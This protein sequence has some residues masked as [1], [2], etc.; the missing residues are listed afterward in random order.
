METEVIEKQEQ[1]VVLDHAHPWP[2]LVSFTEANHSF[3]F[4]R[5]RE[6]S[7]LSRLVRQETLTVFFGK[8]GLGKSSILRAGLSPLLRESDFIPIYIRLNHLEAAP[9]LEDQVEVSIEEVLEREQIDA[10]KPVRSETLWEYFHKKNKDWW[11]KD[12]RLLKPIL[13]FDQFEELMTLGQENPV[14]AA[15]SA[16]FLTELEDLVENRPPASLIARFKEDRDLADQFDHRRADYRVI[17]TLRED[18]LA[19]LEGLRER[20]SAVMLNRLR[21][22]PMNGEQALA[23]VLKPGRDLVAEDVAIRIVDFVSSSERSRLQTEV[24]R[25]QLA[26]R[27]IEPALLSVVLQELN[28]RRI[29]AGQEKITAELVGKTNPTEIF[30]DFYVRGLQ[31]MDG[32][33]REFIEDSLLTSSGARNRIAEEDALTRRGISADVVSKLIDRRIIQRETT[34][35]TKWLELTHDTLADVVRADRAEHQQQRQLELVKAQE[36]E[37]RTKLRRVQKLAAAFAGL[38][39]VALLIL[40][41]AIFEQQKARQ[42]QNSAQQA[43]GLATQTL[44]TLAI[45]TLR[46]IEQNPHIRVED[47]V[48]LTQRFTESIQA[49]R[50]APGASSDLSIRLADLLGTASFMLCDAGLI[51]EGSDY[52]QQAHKLIMASFQP[53]SSPLVFARTEL[54]FLLSQ[55]FHWQ[56]DEQN[57]LSTLDRIGD[58]LRGAQIQGANETLLAESL[59]ARLARTRCDT[60]RSQM[61][62]EDADGV[63]V[64]AISEI[65]KKL[66]STNASVASDELFSRDLTQEL[67]RFY[68]LRYRIARESGQVP[69]FDAIHASFQKAIHGAQSR[70][71]DPENQLWSYYEAE[72]L[73]IAADI[74]QRN[75]SFDKGIA[76]IGTAIGKLHELLLADP[77]NMLW[78]YE[79]GRALCLRAE[80]A[81]AVAK[82]A[83]AAADSEADREAVLILAG[84]DRT[85][86]RKLA[87][88]LRRD[89]HNNRYLSLQLACLVDGTDDSEEAAKKTLKRIATEKERSGPAAYFSRM[90][91]FAHIAS[92]ERNIEKKRYSEAIQHA[93]AGLAGIDRFK[94]TEKQAGFRAIW[95]LQIFQAVLDAGAEE[96]GRMR[97]QAYYDAAQADAKTLLRVSQVPGSF[98]WAST[99]AGFRGAQC[100]R[101]R[102]YREA[103]AALKQAV[104]SV[105]V[106]IKN[107]NQPAGDF[108]N[109]LL[110]QKQIIQADASIGEWNAAID[111][112]R[113]TRAQ[114]SA[115]AGTKPDLGIAFPYV[116]EMSPAIDT[117]LNSLEKKTGSEETTRIA[118]SLRSESK[119]FKEEAEKFEQ[120]YKPKDTGMPSISR[121]NLEDFELKEL[122]AGHKNNYSLVKQ[123]LGWEDTPIYPY[124]D[125]RTLDGT[126]FNE[127]A[128]LVTLKKGIAESQIQ[129][130]R[131]CSLSFYEQG[132]LIE[133][134]YFDAQGNLYTTSIMTAKGMVYH[135]DGTS[136]P[137][138]EANA[139]VPIRL[140]NAE[141]AASYLRFF[142][143]YVLGRY[144]PKERAGG[145]AFHIVENTE[146]LPW[147]AAAST[148][149]RKNVGRLLRPLVIWSDP[150][151]AGDWR[152]TA[153][154]Q[155]SNS[156]FHAEFK[157]HKKGMIEM[158]EDKPVAAEMPL[159]L[160][161]YKRGDH[162]AA[163]LEALDLSAINPPAADDEVD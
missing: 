108:E 157:I 65:E 156:I 47:K 28:S 22:L 83:Q 141:E 34:G 152:A 86:A 46:K 79:L 93:D 97:W 111:V 59:K 37:A 82:S 126:E 87:A 163:K 135:L 140:Q 119:A 88:A 61:S 160:P 128:S 17:L 80:I 72:N 2:G 42:A 118:E 40:G 53:P 112:C 36:R 48:F 26:K 71:A 106:A 18:F 1:G 142:C 76:L 127:A 134:E 49:L 84:N 25:Q 85:T 129:R 70:F 136:P 162:S 131:T 4:G 116:K 6:V 154:V 10:P 153:T 159:N 124:A 133:A 81:T 9:P 21:L 89:Q 146:D 45:G 125:W 43:Q 102:Q 66:T 99:V 23:V 52:A 8:S 20:L 120:I 121:I 101:D 15:R 58:Q 110:W 161:V 73:Q 14:R 104:A 77:Q 5:E 150:E 100:L 51:D 114:V 75:L 24:T 98:S 95:R 38:F 32:A 11:D 117:L 29:Q 16:S 113:E 7:E 92:V 138:H 96:L 33:V 60:L 44:D 94:F 91:V 90:E 12:N 155:Y 109:Y 19:D 107:E 145:G 103:I 123:R 30:H 74:Q 57:T 67:L 147:A 149:L 41:F 143:S 78:R 50:K 115:M 144:D 39:L 3:F 158:V 27:A 31:G 13:I 54:A 64:S 148:E 56:I 69:A 63:A 132:Q 130:I 68:I 139:S 151:V 62:Y 55:R 105:L 35:N 137:I 122:F